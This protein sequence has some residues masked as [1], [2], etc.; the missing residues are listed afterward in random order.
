[1]GL[2]RSLS[3][4]GRLSSLNLARRI[5]FRRDGPLSGIENWGEECMKSKG[6][7]FFAIL[8]I[9]FFT[10]LFAAVDSEAQTYS[11]RATGIKATVITGIAPGV[12]TAVTD[13]GPL[14][15]AGGSI[16][17]GSA[18]ANITN[19]LT[20]GA[21]TVTTSGSGTSSQSTASVATLDM[22]AAGVP[23][24]LRVRA[25]AVSSTTMCTCSNINCN[26][27]STITNLRIGG[28]VITVTGAPNQTVVTA[29]GRYTLTVVIN[30]QMSSPS[31]ITVNALHITLYDSTTDITIDVVV[32]SA[33]SDIVC[34]PN[35]TID[36]YSGRATGVWLATSTL[37]PSSNLATIVSDTGFLPTSG[38]NIA[39]TTASVNVAGTL[40]TGVVTSNTSGGAP[41]GNT[42]T[43][44]SNSTVNNLNPTLVGNVTISAT[45][46]QSNTQCQ[47]GVTPPVSCTG[48]S[49][50]TNLNVVAAGIPVA[51][52]ISG[53]PNQVVVLPAG[54]GTIIINEQISAGPGDLTVNALHVMLTPVGLAS[55]DLIVASSHSDIQCSLSPT[56]AGASIS[57]RVLSASGRP[58][59]QARVRVQDQDGTTWTAMTN[60]FGIYSL[61]DIPVGGTYLVDVSHKRF[62]F[63]SRV[64]NVKDNVT[65]VDFTAEPGK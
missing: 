39:V 50:V 7:K 31:S 49:I 57:G 44:Q 32:S 55:T 37:I 18:S 21:S 1:M 65:D 24:S 54:L 52:V 63:N 23:T 6:S 59:S 22:N 3:D 15:S 53:M 34:T 10:L 4:F 12:T 61:E 45:L 58:V 36:R 17:L 2:G 40:S 26:G 35:P 38:G 46:V 41:G 64:I 8:N 5:S 27:S 48:D 43:S 9:A 28:T 16:T 51:I 56:A 42:E 11:G 13:S 20:A 47:C 30:E 29:V 62:F 14:P 33:H 25:D 60:P 19:I